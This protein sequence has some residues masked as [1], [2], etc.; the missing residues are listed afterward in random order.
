MVSD[1]QVPTDLPHL[2]HAL[3]HRL[4]LTLHPIG[5]SFLTH[6]KCGSA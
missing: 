6:A 1:L 4:K 3:G 2:V 5:F